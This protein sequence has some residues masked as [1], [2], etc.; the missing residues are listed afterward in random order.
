MKKKYFSLLFC[1]FMVS[2]ILFNSNVNSL[3][4]DDNNV[5]PHLETVFEHSNWWWTEAEVVST[6]STSSSQTPSIIDDSEGNIHV[7]WHDLTDYLGAGADVDIFYKVWDSSTKTWGVTELISSESTG[8]SQSPS[9]AIDSDNT[10]HVCWYDQTDYLGSSIDYDIF[11]KYKTSGGSWSLTEVVS[12][13]STAGSIAPDLIIDS[14][15][16][17]HLTW[18]DSTDYL[19]SGSDTDIFYKFRASGGSWVAA[20]V[21][22]TES[23][24]TSNAPD[25]F[26]DSTGNAHVTWKDLTDYLGA[27]VNYDIF[28]KLKFSSSS[29]WSVTEVVST[30]STDGSSEPSVVIDSEDNVHV[31]WSDSTDYS[32]SGSGPSLFYRLKDDH[33][34]TW[35]LTE[36]LTLET[37]GA[38]YYPYMAI[39]S[40]DNLHVIWCDHTDYQS[41]GS[42]S[43]LFYKLQDATSSTWGETV[44]VSTES[45]TD[46][47]T[48][49]LVIDSSDNL[50]AVWFDSTNYL[51]SGTD[52]DVYYTKFVGPP[53]APQFLTAS[54]SYSTSGDISLN[55][56]DVGRTTAYNLYRE[57]AYITS[58]D[59]LTPLVRINV[60][61][62]VDTIDATGTYFYAVAAENEYGNSTLSTVEDVQVDK[63]NL[64]SFISN[65][66][67]IVA[68]VLLGVQLVLFFVA[69]SIK[70]TSG[71]TSKK[72][73]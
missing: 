57:T 34:G 55:W 45:I 68:G 47:Y 23:T 2:G 29:L 63:S 13:E 19:G 15:D 58:S 46:I 4:L 41:S 25:L 70:K 14:E 40:A 30:V 22:S 60:S 9:I 16:N 49:S 11:Y 72:K 39:D 35:G 73:K 54:P 32:G 37:P 18:Q 8:I 24:G 44:V 53:A 5:F 59:G 3:L 1:I 31:L 51:G 52:F 12:T 36:V 50:H 42:D 48:S 64:L 43:D 69:I 65:E 6:E 21:V 20:E 33:S 26:V 10:L 56:S 61:N 27:G 67:L 38:S 28:Y 17:L 66:V 7:A 62:Y 71:K